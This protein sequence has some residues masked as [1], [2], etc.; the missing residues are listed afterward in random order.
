[1]PMPWIGAFESLALAPLFRSLFQTPFQ[2]RIELPIV[3][4]ILSLETNRS[5]R[6]QTDPLTICRIISTTTAII[7]RRNERLTRR[8]AI[9]ENIEE[10]KRL[11]A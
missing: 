10:I 9:E 5:S 6:Q 8:T 11:I 7:K 3:S 2:T 1:M 4:C